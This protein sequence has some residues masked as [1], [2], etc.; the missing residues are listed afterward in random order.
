MQE[1]KRILHLI[2]GLEIGGAE[3]MLLKTL[4]RLQDN[5]DNR[6]CCI[7]G[8]GP[9]AAKLEQARIPVTFLD[10]NSI[11]D[12]IAAIFRFRKIIRGFHPEILVTYLIHADLF[13]RV[14]G[15]FFGIKK[16]ICNQRG[17]LLRWEFLR[18]IDRATKFLVTGY[19][20][21]TE[22][23]KQELI[24]KL[25]LPKKKLTVIPN[26]IDMQ[27]F[28][29]DLDRDAKREGLDLSAG[30]IAITCVSKLRK[31]KGH[32]YLLEAFE[33]L[34]DYAEQSEESRIHDENI[35][36]LIVGDGE[37]REKLL[38]QVKGYQSKPAIHF[39]GNRDDV[40]EILKASDIF[41]LPTLG[42]GM[43]NAIMEAMASGLPVITTDIPENHELI[44]NN[45][46]GMLVPPK[47]SLALVETIKRF[48]SDLGKSETLGKNAKRDICNRFGVRVVISK[49]NQLFK[50]L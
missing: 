17:K 19:I 13:G 50:S 48:I 36:L 10:L 27:E 33:Q 23:A 16:I 1:R 5:F 15:R 29:F 4:P 42:E 8:R 35:K 7:R 25:R 40:K 2:T 38:E 18:I 44:R 3:M 43:S 41:I 24:R 14:F 34:R 20:V 21:Q 37:Q 32:E 28:D 39:L 45:E 6:V 49:L 11:F 12:I 46:T 9:I 47:D 30:D 31:G 26:S 22:T